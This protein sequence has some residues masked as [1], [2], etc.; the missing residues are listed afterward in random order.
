MI[1]QRNGTSKRYVDIT[2]EL[3]HV[4]PE[5]ERSHGVS[6]GWRTGKLVL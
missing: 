1:L 3:A 5:A 4:I 6:S 2:Q